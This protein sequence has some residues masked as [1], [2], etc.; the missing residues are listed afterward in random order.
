MGRRLQP[1][2]T[3]RAKG[4]GDHGSGC[5]RQRPLALVALALLSM[6]T[7]SSP[8]SLGI[9]SLGTAQITPYGDAK[10]LAARRARLSCVVESLARLSLRTTAPRG[11][12]LPLYDAIV[13]L[14]ISLVM[15]LRAMGLDLPIEIPH[16]GDL[17]RDAAHATTDAG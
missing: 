16:C 4:P 5:S 6:A 15:E 3:A 14:G 10:E 2:L 12:V 1:Q 11:L 8:P 17:G 9:G 7:Q 13:F